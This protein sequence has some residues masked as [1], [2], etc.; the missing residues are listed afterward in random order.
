VKVLVFTSSSSV[1]YGDG[2]KLENVDERVPYPDKFNSPYNRT[3]AEAEK[4][5]IR[6]NDKNGLRTVSLRP[7]GIFGPND[8]LVAS[9]I[10][11]AYYASQSSLRIG[12]NENLADFT[13]VSNV[14]HAHLLASSRLLSGT[15]IA[16]HEM[17]SRT[18]WVTK[19]IGHRELPTS[20]SLNSDIKIKPA[21]P[22][23]PA[24]RTRF[25]Q[26][27]PF[28]GTDPMDQL[29]VA[30]E[31]FNITNCEPVFFWDFP[32]AIWKEYSG[33][34]PR[35]LWNVPEGLSYPVAALAEVAAWWKGKSGEGLNRGTVR[36][37]VAARYFNVE[38][39]RR[40]LGYEPIVGLEEGIK[41]T[42]A[43]YRERDIAAGT[44]VQY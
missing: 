39:A 4:I 28:I 38:K 34:S 35:S 17:N 20:I 21:E 19:S 42:A 37:M 25:D 6:A 14:V 40:V 41:L 5:V 29:P 26:F 2:E 30:G 1:V 9:G 8:S 36:Y 16:R 24:G 22:P 32:L 31:V 10:M 3:K 13:Y 15:T 7:S 23:I 27:F 44:F 18:P 33:W 43:W 12:S 11:K